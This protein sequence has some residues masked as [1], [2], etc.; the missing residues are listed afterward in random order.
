MYT[1]ILKEKNADAIIIS[2]PMN[3]R[4]VSGFK[5]GEGIVYVSGKQ[6]VLVTDSRYTEAA[7]KESSFTLIEEKN[8]H[9][10]EE[11]LKDCIEKDAAEKVVFED[12]AMLCHDFEKL[13]TALPQVKEWIPAGE[14]VN[15][16]RM[17]KT[18]EEIRLMKEAAAIADNAFS[19][20][21][22]IIK[23]GMTELEGAAELEYLMK[24]QGAQK[25]SFDTIF[26]SGINSSMPHAVP[27]Q[28]KL[29]KGDFV[30]MDFGCCV[31]GY[32]SDMT[33]TIVLGKATDKQKEVYN[34]VLRANEAAL[35]AVRPG[36]KG[37]E[38]DAVARD[39]I[40]EAGYG[41]YFGHGLGHSVGLYI[42]ENP[43][44]SPSEEAVI[45]AGYIETVEPG[46]YIPGWGGVRIEDMILVTETGYEFMCHSPKQL[47]ELD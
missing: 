28:K 29:E 35:A 33:R 32:C 18:P 26:A 46:I 17:V 30:T 13:K 34:T 27:S 36:L 41:D 12:M 10:R 40:R 2:D 19:G 31:D 24:K 15:D 7:S 47:I 16:L 6:Q 9:K 3:M 25:L 14:T 11:I 22:K 1:D 5:G 21:L 8:T 37:K 38:V 43:R 20:I 39:L 42:H 44:F 4:Y 23:P 45:K